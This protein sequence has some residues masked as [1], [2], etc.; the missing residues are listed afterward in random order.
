MSR[1]PMSSTVKQRLPQQRLRV[2]LRIGDRS[3]GR[4]I[5]KF[6]IWTSVQYYQ[7]TLVHRS[8]SSLAYSLRSPSHSYPLLPRTS[9]HRPAKALSARPC[10]AYRPQQVAV[11]QAASPGQACFVRILSVMKWSCS[12]RMNMSRRGRSSHGVSY[13]YPNRD[14]PMTSI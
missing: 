4:H 7:D 13:N 3:S 14:V 2:Q 12:F 6:A 9:L 8:R 1:R 11:H 5:E 10:L